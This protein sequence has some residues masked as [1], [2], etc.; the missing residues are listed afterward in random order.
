MLGFLTLP[1]RPALLAMHCCKL[2]AAS[3]HCPLFILSPCVAQQPSIALSS[4]A[5]GEAC[6]IDR[7]RTLS[8]GS[9]VDILTRRDETFWVPEG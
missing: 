3:A 6:A 2:N 1:F 9:R 5:H 7:G 4:V 8:F